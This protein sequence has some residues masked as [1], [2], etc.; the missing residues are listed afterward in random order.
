MGPECTLFHKSL[1]E[2]ISTKSGERYSDV[3]SFIRCKISFMCVKSALLCLRGSRSVS[4]KVL[5]AGNDFGLFNQDLHLN[6]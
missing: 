2:K 3:I 5:E 1:A 4:K 6:T